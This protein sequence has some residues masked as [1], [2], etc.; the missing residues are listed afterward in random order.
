MRNNRLAFRLA[1]EINGKTWSNDALPKIELRSKLIADN[2]VA[3]ARIFHRS[4]QKFFE[5]L[6]KLPLDD[7]TNKRA[8]IDRLLHRNKK[9]YIGVFGKIT[10]AYGVLEEQSSGNLHYHGILFGGWSI[11]HLMGHVHIREVRA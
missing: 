11:E 7:L 3:A 4:L 1:A 5:I 9:K 6:V 10:A 2:P 8:H